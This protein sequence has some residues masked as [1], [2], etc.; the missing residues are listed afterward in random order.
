MVATDL[1]HIKCSICGSRVAT[2]N[3]AWPASALAV[4]AGFGVGIILM[5]L[6]KAGDISTATMVVGAVAGIVVLD[7]LLG[8]FIINFS[9]MTASSSPN[10]R[11]DSTGGS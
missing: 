7:A 3:L 2:T 10:S 5:Q 6:R 1:R 8:L 4:L 11:P 9:R